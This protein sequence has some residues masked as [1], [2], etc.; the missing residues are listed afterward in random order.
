MLEFIALTPV[1]RATAFD[2]LVAS[3][4]Y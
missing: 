3:A 4:V 2:T 1:N